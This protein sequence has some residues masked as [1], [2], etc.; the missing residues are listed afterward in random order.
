CFGK[1]YQA[2]W[3][4]PPCNNTGG[5]GISNPTGTISAL[6]LCPTCPVVN[7]ANFSNVPLN[8]AIETASSFMELTDTMQNDIA[9]VALFHE[10][11]TTTPI[12]FNDYNQV[13]LV[14]YGYSNMKNALQH[15]FVTG[16]LNESS[17]VPV[18]HNSVEQFMEVINIRK[19]P[20][21]AQNVAE[22]FFL[23][24]DE[25]LVFRLIGQRDEAIIRLEAIDNCFLTQRHRQILKN[26][27]A[28][29]KV[30]RDV[31]N[32]TVPLMAA[33]DLMDAIPRLEIKSNTSTIDTTAT[34]HPTAIIGTNVTIGSNVV[35]E[36]DVFIGSN[37]VIANNVIIKKNSIIGEDVIIEENTLIEKE[38]EIGNFTAIG[39]YT[40]IKQNT[41]IGE[42]TT[43]NDSI[44][45]E[46][47]VTIYDYV[48]IETNVLIKKETTIGNGVFIG[49]N[50]IISKEI[51][52]G[53]LAII[54]E[55]AEINDKVK[56]GNK[57]IIAKAAKV[58][59]NTETGKEVLVEEN[60]H[61]PAN[62]EICDNENV[63]SN[64]NFSNVCAANISPPVLVSNTNSCAFAMGYAQTRTN[65][66]N[67]FQLDS[68]VKLVTDEEVTFKPDNLSSFYNWEFGDCGTSTN[69]QASYTFRKPGI[70]LVKLIQGTT[71]DTVVYYGAVTVFPNPKSE[72]SPI[73][74]QCLADED[75]KLNRATTIDLSQPICIPTADCT[76][77]IPLKEENCRLKLSWDFDN[78]STKE[79]T[80]ALNDT[81]L[82]NGNIAVQ[83]DTNNV[84]TPS[85][86]TSIENREETHFKWEKACEKDTATA[87]ITITNSFKVSMAATGCA[88][89]EVQFTSTTFGGVSPFTYSWVFGNGLTASTSSP[90][91]T[92][93]DTGMLSV[94]LMITDANGCES[95]LLSAIYISDCNANART[96]G[97]ANAE[98]TADGNNK[99]TLTVNDEI[100]VYPNPTAGQVTFE[101]SLKEN[102]A[103]IVI[104]DIMGKVVSSVKINGDN[105][106]KI[107]LSN[108]PKGVYL[109]KVIG[110]TKVIL[111]DKIILME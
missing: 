23:E 5:G 49:K 17:C 31:I 73:V 10:I 99:T 85:L 42:H 62:K 87:E 75:V 24:L 9:A 53:E 68:D 91:I 83:Y 111:S 107:D 27:L 33:I 79:E 93:A 48:D 90:L 35:I 12:D 25:A 3:P 26:T 45:I 58:K 86:I 80:I 50:A 98:N 108:F 89:G 18:L 97:N 1:F 100:K 2:P 29:T 19:A 40:I 21:S 14:K 22:Q 30:E 57:N 105:R 36:Q 66:L 92:V 101:Y 94:E 34:V 69:E 96:T 11:F 61:I 71:C 32:G 51:T 37:T 15:C 41:T 39:S 103:Q 47:D 72:I 54:R 16:R 60:I 77:F 104:T 13:F 65:F 82:I 4:P 6:K 95:H 43:I 110:Q 52:I 38:V 102:N 76:P 109:Y 70:Y 55:N 8:E 84:F 44:V 59:N 67:G 46:K 63:T 106:T 81:N 20:V 74:P 78:D 7:S 64:F 88:S 56:V 28:T